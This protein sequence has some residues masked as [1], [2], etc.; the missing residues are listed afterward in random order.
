MKI[1][2]LQLAI[3]TCLLLMA[4]CQS[5]IEDLVI[6]RQDKKIFVANQP[7]KSRLLVINDTR[8]TIEIQGMEFC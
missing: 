7:N 2:M 3:L 4:G 8:R 1:V 5:D 6:I